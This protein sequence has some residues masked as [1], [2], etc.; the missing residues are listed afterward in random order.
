MNLLIALYL[1][2]HPEDGRILLKHVDEVDILLNRSKY[3]LDGFTE[4]TQVTD[5]ALITTS[6]ELCKKNCYSDISIP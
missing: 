3:V 4:M 2:E 5:T 1:T 6:L